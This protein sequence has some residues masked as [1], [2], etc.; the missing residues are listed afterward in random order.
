MQQTVF[1]IIAYAAILVVLY[2]VYRLITSL[3]K[4]T[5]TENQRPVIITVEGGIIQDIDNIPPG[6]QII[7]HDYDAEGCEGPTEVDDDGQHYI[8][9]IYFEAK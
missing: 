5:S 4:P 6:L 3:L 1:L 2:C 7:V 9:S 8:E